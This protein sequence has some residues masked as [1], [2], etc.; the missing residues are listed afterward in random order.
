MSK[1]LHLPVPAAPDLGGLGQQV[2]RAA[3]GGLKLQPAAVPLAWGS[4]QKGRRGRRGHRVPSQ[5][6]R[7]AG[8]R[9]LLVG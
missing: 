6:R 3:V 1:S 7:K 9:A 4:Q 5:T 2:L 8:S